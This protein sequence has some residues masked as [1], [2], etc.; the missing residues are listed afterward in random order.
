MIV[1]YKRLT[2]EARKP[3]I[4]HNSDFCYDLYATSIDDLGNGVYRYHTGLAFQM[5]RGKIFIADHIVVDLKNEFGT[6][7]KLSLDVR[8]RSSVYKTGMVLANCEPTVDEEYTGEVM[9]VFYHLI[10]SLPKYEVGD[11]IGQMKVGF[12]V[13]I[14]FTEVEEF[15]ETS[16]GEGGFGSTGK[17]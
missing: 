3:Y 5:E 13:P 11:R 1:K 16:R 10:P 8:P 4:K 6:F 12:T 9:L 2:E 7:V 17:K 14:E 15:E